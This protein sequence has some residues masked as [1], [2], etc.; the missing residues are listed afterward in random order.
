MQQAVGR[1]TVLGGAA[2]GGL[3]LAGLTWSDAAA[4]S[5]QGR[6]PAEVDVVVVGGG[7][8]GL[9]AARRLRRRGLSVLVLEARDRVGGRV[10][11]HQL[12]NGSQIES[13]GAFIGPTQNHIATLA[14][15]IGVTTFKEYVDGNSVYVS[16]N[17]RQT[18]QGT[19]PTYQLGLLAPDAL[20][21]QERLD[22]MAAQ[23]DVNAPWQHPRAGTWDRMTARQWLVENAVDDDIV[24]LIQDWSQPAL[25]ADLDEVSL[26]F[27]LW[28]LACSGDA[29][30]KG[31]FERNADTSGGAQESRFVGGSG[32]IP[33]GLAHDLGSSVA[34]QAPV[35]WVDQSKPGRV[36]VHSARGVVRARRVVVACPP[37]LVRE[38]RFTPEMPA[39]R[40]QLMRRMDMGNLMKCDAVYAEPWWREKG[41]N[42]FGISDHGAVRAAFDN[43]PA[44]TACGVLLAF[45]GG[46]TWREYGVES[47]A[48]RRAAV[49]AG[50]AE[51]FGDEALRP[52]QYVEHDWNHDPWTRGGPVAIMGPETLT[53]YGPWLRRPHG[54]VHWAGTETATYWTGYMDGAVSAGERA[55]REV[56]GT[57]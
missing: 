30:H 1:R 17:R 12:R 37:P 24:K 22:H 57:L 41:L 25:G 52:V 10:H 39:Q 5:L 11:N 44:D 26:L 33:L 45:V 27:T 40:R 16:G 29:S 42:G 54:R 20:L 15:D 53:T 51:M 36:R 38:I 14:R 21:L 13:G 47:R 28:Y 35:T 18:Y 2:V 50:F 7:L 8:S 43:S 23:I 34:L 56:A 4:A 48:D 9:V 32:L 3:A 55:A 6:L 49:L 46:S 19:V 31:T